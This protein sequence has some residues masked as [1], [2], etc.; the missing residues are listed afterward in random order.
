ML[1][2]EAVGYYYV[3]QLE[4][5]KELIEKTK[6]LAQRVKK[7]KH[8]YLYGTSNKKKQEQ[9]MIKVQEDNFKECHREL[10]AFK[11]MTTLVCGAG[12]LIV[13]YFLSSYFQG[14]V[15]G[16]LPFDPWGMVGNMSHRGL[17]GEDMQ[18]CSMLF[19]Y[20]L[21]Q[22]ILRGSVS[23]L[24]GTESPRMPVEHQTPKWLQDMVDPKDQ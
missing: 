6:N 7:L 12:T 8:E 17:G 9:K 3:Y 16:K 5:Y 19:L 13:M 2:I 22:M 15:I 10:G 11:G 21:L 4:E 14:L 24:A 18:E 1:I 20:M 23:K